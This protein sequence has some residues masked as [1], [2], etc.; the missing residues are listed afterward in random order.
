MTD[1]VVFSLD[2]DNG[3]PDRL[4]VYDDFTATDNR[5][6][7]FASGL[8]NLGFIKAAVRRSARFL[9]VMSIVGLLAGIGYYVK[10]PHSYQASASVLLTLTPYDNPLTAVN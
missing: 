10:S 6:A 2:G 4:G 5:S 1:P 7:E 3:E 8:V 9:F